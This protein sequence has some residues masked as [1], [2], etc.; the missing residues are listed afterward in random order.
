MPPVLLRVSPLGRRR[1]RRWVLQVRPWSWRS[2]RGPV[3]PPRLPGVLPGILM[4][5][6]LGR[7]AVLARRQLLL[8]LLLLLPIVG[9]VWAGRSRLGGGMRRLGS[10]HGAIPNHHRRVGWGL[11]SPALRQRGL[12]GCR[13]RVSRV[14]LRGRGVSRV[15]LSPIGMRRATHSRCLPVRHASSSKLRFDYRRMRGAYRAER[16]YP[17]LNTPSLTVV[18]EGAKPL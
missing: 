9:G 5:V 3:L 15:L 2:R 8:R 10:V 16:C 12:P 14:V 4:L 17:E 18:R 6:A 7:V 11:R 1:P 13:L